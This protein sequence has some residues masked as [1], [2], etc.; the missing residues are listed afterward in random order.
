MLTGLLRSGGGDETIALFVNW[1]DEPVESVPLLSDGIELDGIDGL[2]RLEPF[3]VAAIPCSG[4]GGHG[5]G[6]AVLAALEG[7]DARA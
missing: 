5:Q 3:A 7:S 6:S 2:L 1:W 4:P